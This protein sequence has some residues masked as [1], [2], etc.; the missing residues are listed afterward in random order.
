MLHSRLDGMQ[1]KKPAKENGA[2]TAKNAETKAED[3]EAWRHADPY[4]FFPSPAD[5]NKVGTLNLQDYNTG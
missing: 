5:N 4:A 2:V 1:E 3:T